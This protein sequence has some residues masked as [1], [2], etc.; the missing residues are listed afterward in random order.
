MELEF[1]H[2]GLAAVVFVWLLPAVIVLLVELY[3]AD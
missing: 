1:W 3:C 2:I